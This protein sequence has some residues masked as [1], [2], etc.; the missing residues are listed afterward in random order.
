MI[1]SNSIF[2]NQNKFWSIGTGNH[3]DFPVEIPLTTHVPTACSIQGVSGVTPPYLPGNRH[4]GHKPAPGGLPR[5][6]CPCTEL[7]LKKQPALIGCGQLSHPPPH[8]SQ[9]HGGMAWCP[10]AWSSEKS[11][12]LIRAV[13]KVKNRDSLLMSPEG[14]PNILPKRAKSSAFRHSPGLRR[15]LG[16]IAEEKKPRQGNERFSKGNL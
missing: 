10:L 3:R 14:F 4:L 6:P 2:F 15:H 5:A 13:G 7:D 16:L 12:I 9:G 11:D 1:L 8:P